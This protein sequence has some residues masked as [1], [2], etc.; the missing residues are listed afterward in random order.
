MNILSCFHEWVVQM[1]KKST[2]PYVTVFYDANEEFEE[3]QESDEDNKH[4]FEEEEEEE[5]VCPVEV[6]VQHAYAS[7]AHAQFSW[8]SIHFW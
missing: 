3:E 2:W 7:Q 1:G 6:E 5:F 4:L 8:T